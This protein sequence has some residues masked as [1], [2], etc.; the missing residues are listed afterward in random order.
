M[1]RSWRCSTRRFE[2]GLRRHLSIDL[3]K[4]SL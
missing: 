4:P 2:T 3:F 1:G